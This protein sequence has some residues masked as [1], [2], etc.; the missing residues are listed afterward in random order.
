MLTKSAVK[1]F[2]LVIIGGGSA[3]YAATRTGAALGLE[4]AVIEGGSELGGLCILRGCM[5]S[6]TLIESANRYRVIRRAAEFG[7]RAERFA[8]DLPAIVARKR[9]L[10][11]EFADYRAGQL[12]DGRF[13]LLRGRARFVSPHE[14]A[15]ARPGGGE[16]RV[17][18]RAFVIATGS[19]HWSPPVPGLA[20]TPHLTSDDALDLE[21]LPESLIVLGGG[22]IALEMAHYFEALGS[23]VTLIQRSAHLLS[24]F[25][26]D[27]GGAVAEAFRDRGMIVETGTAIERVER[28][29]GGVR[30]V[31]Q[32]NGAR[33]AAEAAAL[34]VALGRAPATDGLGLDAAG[35]RLDRGRV[36]AD[37][38]QRTSA[39]H[40]FAAGDVCGPEEVVHVAV[41]QGE[42]AAV[43]AARLLGADAP[44]RRTDGEI[45]LFAAFCEPQ[46]AV[47]GLGERDAARLGVDFKAATYPFD[48]HGKSIVAAERH[49]FV[50]LIAER[51]SGRLLGGAVVGP[52]ASELIHEIAVALRFGAT[53]AALAAAP[54]YHPTLSEIWTYPA[55]ELAGL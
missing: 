22:A 49:G 7:L 23:H 1:T 40:I 36:I 3:G 41:R 32:K 28:A 14:L 16:E 24:A 4:T 18:G 45:R 38:A 12:Q 44:E 34:L 2:D 10:V 8:P 50:K 11:K 31:Y 5:P 20:E 13:A 35:V 37:G 55:E 39:G 46:V 42:A 51:G 26:P 9:A 21:E 25:D 54:H 47:A 30:V 52:E 33:R 27:I 19:A 6:K 53:A 29:D 48:D 43:N 15:V 17:A